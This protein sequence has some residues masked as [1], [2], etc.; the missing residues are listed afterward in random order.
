M[1][2]WG[3]FAN[4]RTGRYMVVVTVS[5]TDMVRHWT[6]AAYTDRKFALR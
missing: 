4:I 6:I 5:D 3:R 1:G 2:R